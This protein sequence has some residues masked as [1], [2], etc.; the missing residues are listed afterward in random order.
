V[1]LSEIAKNAQKQVYRMAQYMG[2]YRHVYWQ[3]YSRPHCAMGV[4]RDRSPC[5][6][7]RGMG[8]KLR[9]IQKP[10]VQFGAMV[11]LFLLW[12]WIGLTVLFDRKGPRTTTPHH[13]YRYGL[14]FEGIAP[15]YQ[16]QAAGGSLGFGVQLR[17]FSSGPL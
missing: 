9:F 8:D 2:H 15:F 16:P 6:L 4:G 7:G 11:F 3:Y 1:T 12:T 10:E 14:T 13:D 5:L 17:N